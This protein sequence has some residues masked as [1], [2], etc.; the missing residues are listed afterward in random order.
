MCKNRIYII[1]IFFDI[2][3]KYPRIKELAFKLE[4]Y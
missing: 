2:V 3:D 1:F 4:L